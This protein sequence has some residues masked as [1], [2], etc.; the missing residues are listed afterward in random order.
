[1]FIIVS[2]LSILSCSTNMFAQYLFY[3]YTY[4][5]GLYNISIEPYKIGFGEY[6]PE[7]TDKEMLFERGDVI[8]SN[9]NINYNFSREGTTLKIKFSNNNYNNTYLD[10]PL[11]YYKGY[12]ANYKNNVNNIVLPIIKGD[13]NIIRV[14]LGKYRDGEITVRYNGTLIQRLSG[15][16]SA[17]SLIIFIIYM[18][19]I[20]ILNKRRRKYENEKIIYN[21]T[22]V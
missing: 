21:N 2:M 19:K 9:N 4:Y 6:L 13:N 18:M 14:K 20:K 22:N 3:G 5:K 1:M 16:V 12:E 15:I 8:T 10:L 17:L 7:D 11:L